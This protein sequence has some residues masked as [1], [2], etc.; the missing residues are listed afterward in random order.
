[1]TNMHTAVRV[2]DAALAL[3][4]GRQE[5]RVAEQEALVPGAY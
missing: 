5:D 3:D 1:M 2:Q 4:L